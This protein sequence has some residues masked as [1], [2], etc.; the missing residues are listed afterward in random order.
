MGIRKAAFGVALLGALG[1]WGGSAVGQESSPT[2]LFVPPDL[3]R[4]DLPARVPDVPYV[5]TPQLVV[6]EMLALAGVKPGDVLYDLGSG[7]GRIV[8]TA[9]KNLG[10]RGVG[11]D[12]NPERIQEAEANARAAGVQDL[13]EF[14]EEDLFKADFSEATVVT[15]Y[16]LPSVND[17]LKPKL[18]R[19]LKPGTRIVSHAFDIDGWE[20]ERVVE[21]DG[22]TLYLWIVPE[23]PS[24]VR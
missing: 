6:D 23:N 8:V 18:L 16:L 9:A 1:P 4:A 24:Q 7:D 19:E 17:R 12:I 11:I 13:T 20:P 3:G 15:M 14:R 10:V 22:R 2:P 5:P 21:V